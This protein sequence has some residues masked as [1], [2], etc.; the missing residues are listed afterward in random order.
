MKS[1]N[2]E[3][4]S[5]DTGYKQ[6]E[7]GVI[8]EE[9]LL[10]GPELLVRPHKGGF[11]D[12]FQLLFMDETTLSLDP[13]LRACWMKMGVQKRIPL[14]AN[15][16]KKRCHVFGPITGS[17]IKLNRGLP[18]GRTAKPSS[19]FWNICWSKNIQQVASSWFLCFLK[20]YVYL[21][22]FSQ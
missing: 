13:V 1:V 11:Q 20:T 5:S 12:D 21:L 9:W 7:V 22:S 14:P 3:N 19:P 15:Q 2:Q 6:T 16:E 4:H 10:G 17:T 8:P 18:R